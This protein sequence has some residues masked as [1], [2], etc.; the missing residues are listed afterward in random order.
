VNYFIDRRASGFAVM[1]ASTGKAVAYY[2]NRHDAVRAALALDHGAPAES[3]R[4]VDA[5]D[6]RGFSR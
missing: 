5:H 1:D 6:G 4:F 2:K 3:A